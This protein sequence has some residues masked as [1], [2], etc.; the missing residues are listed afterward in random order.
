MLGINKALLDRGYALQHAEMNQTACCM[1][2]NA[3]AGGNA[4]ALFSSK[5]IEGDGYLVW[6]S[7]II[8]YDGAGQRT[9]EAQRIRAKL[10]NLRLDARINSQLYNN[11]CKECVKRLNDLNE[12]NSD[13]AYVEKHLSQIDH[14]EYAHLKETLKST[15]NNALDNCYEKISKKSSEL[16]KSSM[17]F[18][19]IFSQGVRGS[20]MTPLMHR[21]L[22]TSFH[23]PSLHPRIIPLYS[24]RHAYCSNK[25]L[26]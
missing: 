18:S 9:P 6:S 25:V 26:K 23:F 3:I 21:S 1:I 20:V 8:E 5:G 2:A 14:P 22:S 7:L 24:I 17:P 19:A 11:K 4:S 10:D 15:N 16:L 13:N 12:A